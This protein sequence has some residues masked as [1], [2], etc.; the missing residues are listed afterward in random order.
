[1]GL[2][3]PLGQRGAAGA[4]LGL[5]LWLYSSDTC[6]RMAFGANRVRAIIRVRVRVRPRLRLRLRLRAAM[7]VMGG[8]RL[9]VTVRAGWHHSMP[10]FGGGGVRVWAR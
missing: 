5:L 9:R 10:T 1:M 3:M 6:R 4:T 2:G 7:V 8:V